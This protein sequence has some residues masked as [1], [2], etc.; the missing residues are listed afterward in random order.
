[1]PN[2]FQRPNWLQVEASRRYLG[3][4][5]HLQHLAETLPDDGVVA[6]AQNVANALRPDD[7]VTSS[8]PAP[9]A[10]DEFRVGDTIKIKLP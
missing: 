9:P 1:M 6:V 2:T 5:P 4:F 8:M 3:R 7:S 10:P